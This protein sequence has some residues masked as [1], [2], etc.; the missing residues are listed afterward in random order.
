MP[1]AP[2]TCNAGKVLPVR[3]HVGAIRLFEA[4][5]VPLPDDVLTYHRDKITERAKAEKRAPSFQMV[6][7]DIYAVSKSRLIG[8]PQ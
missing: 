2:A 4:G 5:N 1:F 8:R 7:D 6:V 3:D